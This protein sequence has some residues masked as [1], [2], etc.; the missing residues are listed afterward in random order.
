MGPPLPER[1]HLVDFEGN[2]H[3]DVI[4]IG[5]F[6]SKIPMN[7]V[8]LRECLA[9][10]LIEKITRLCSKIKQSVLEF[11]LNRD[12]PLHAR[13]NDLVLIHAPK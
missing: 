4:F 13:F 12:T 2:W 11:T 10:D 8:L 1:L 9:K 3:G 7:H 6:A 5:R